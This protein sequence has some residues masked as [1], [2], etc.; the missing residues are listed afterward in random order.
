M[1]RYLVIAMLSIALAAC[2]QN[3]SQKEGS[4]IAPSTLSGSYTSGKDTFVFSA[5]GKVTAKNKLFP[6]KVTTYSI[7]G[8]K[9][10]MKFPDGY[11]MT[12]SLNS[13]GSIT[14]DSNINY[15]KSD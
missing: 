8:G 4:A 10:S 2:N 15:K 14:S 11:P 12:F 5:D 7:E 13:D 1:K 3:A 9:V 6:D